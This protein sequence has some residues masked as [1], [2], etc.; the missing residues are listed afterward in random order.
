MRYNYHEGV[1]HEKKRPKWLLWIILL[2]IIIAGIYYGLTIFA[3]QLISMPL[4]DK[5]TPDATMQKM[6]ATAPSQQPH[7]YLPQI[8]VDLAV[9]LEDA[10]PDQPGTIAIC[11]PRFVMGKT[12]WQTRANS[13]FYNL[14]KLQNNDEFY[15]DYDGQ[16]YVYHV[17]SVQ[18]GQAD[19]K[20]NG[21]QKD[22]KAILY[23]CNHQGKDEEF[24]VVEANQSGTVAQDED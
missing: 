22:K 4:S 7:L 14:A 23:A 21:D 10:Q 8:N 1:T 5:S 24:V 20:E 17:G 19:T 9:N 11:A 15:L 13:P 16:R 18:P 12:P 3:P 2:I 6:K